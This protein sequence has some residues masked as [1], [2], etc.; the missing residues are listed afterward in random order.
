[1]NDIEKYFKENTALS[2]HKWQHYFDVYD[3]HF[4]RYRGTDVHIVE[5]GVSEG[6]SLQMWKNYFGPDC[7]IYGVD[8]NPYC[9]ELEED[10]IKIFIGDQEDPEFLQELQERIPRIDILLDDGGHTMNQQLLTFEM[11]FP[12]LSESATYICEDTHTSYWNTFG[13]GFRREGTF[14]EHSK[15]LVDD[16][17]G[18]HKRGRNDAFQITQYTQSIDSI[19]FYDSMVVIEKEKRVK[20]E[21]LQSGTPR[22]T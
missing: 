15:G 14:M 17:H 13:G 5:F 12:H 18:F 22:F 6:G 1:M 10:R 21:P 16:L 11:M 8:I 19:H 2:I 4:S 20:P 7:K 3:R 9:K